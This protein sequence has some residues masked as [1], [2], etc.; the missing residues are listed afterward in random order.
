MILRDSALASL[1]TSWVNVPSPHDRA[2]RRSGERA[3]R[4]TEEREARKRTGERAARKRTG[5]REARKRTEER[6]SRKRTGEREARRSGERESRRSGERESRRS[7][8]RAGRKRTAEREARKRTGEREAPSGSKSHSKSKEELIPRGKPVP[9]DEVAKEVRQVVGS[10]REACGACGYRRTCAFAPVKLQIE[11]QEQPETR[12]RHAAILRKGLKELSE[13]RGNWR[14]ALIRMMVGREKDALLAGCLLYA[15]DRKSPDRFMELLD[16][17]FKRC[18][19]DR[20]KAEA[21]VAAEELGDPSAE[22]PSLHGVDP[23]KLQARMFRGQVLRTAAFFGDEDIL[24]RMQDLLVLD[25]DDEHRLF[26][27]EAVAALALLI[28]RR[29]TGSKW[30]ESLEQDA[31]GMFRATFAT[32]DAGSGA[33]DVFFPYRRGNRR[34]YLYLRRDQN[35]TERLT[36]VDKVRIDSLLYRMFLVFHTDGQKTHRVFKE[37]C[38]HINVRA[39]KYNVRHVLS[40]FERMERNDLFLLGIYAPALARAVGHHLEVEEFHQLVKFLYSMRSEGGSK[41][42]PFV[43][44]HEKVINAREEWEDL[45][46]LLGSDFIKDVF[47]VLFRLN[48]SY[49]RRVYTTPTYLKIGEVAYLLTALSGWNP[50][51]LEIELKQGKKPLAFVAY[52]M[53]PPGKW[54]KIRAGKLTRARE[55]ALDRSDDEELHHAG[56][57][58]MQYFALLHGYE[59]FEDLEQAVNDPEWT[60]PERFPTQ[61]PAELEASGEDFSDYDD[62]PEEDEDFVDEDESDDEDGEEEEVFMLVDEEE[63]YEDGRLKTQRVPKQSGRRRR[64]R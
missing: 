14:K 7:G 12:H 50:K 10:L 1:Y 62:E 58:G 39:G 56:K 34:S 41:G 57:V 51:G 13:I 32:R 63:T 61:L 48:A 24:K 55:R 49:K 9:M 52:G 15:V 19:V 8:E 3:T 45:I 21:A 26:Q 25:A 59:R 35:L 54:S 47:S 33:I 6:A 44:S 38:R 29:L 30:I 43:A 60:P 64:S 17:T 27:Y 16:Y 4:R 20:L 5:E 23:E 11:R 28:G 37:L 53:Q 31:L 36:S 2:Q 40:G 18:D 22:G 42:K 46:D